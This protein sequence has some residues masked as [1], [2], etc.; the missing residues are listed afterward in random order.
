[1][2]L[3]HGIGMKIRVRSNA[4]L[5]YCSR[6]PKDN[7]RENTKETPF[8]FQFHARQ[9]KAALKDII[10]IYKMASQKEFATEVLQCISVYLSNINSLYYLCKNL[11]I[12]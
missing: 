12:I 6:C 8:Y 11:K 10:A 9:T 4:S 1:M 3:G 5:I 2:K 7:F